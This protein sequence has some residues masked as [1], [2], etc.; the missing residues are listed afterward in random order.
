MKHSSLLFFCS[1]NFLFSNIYV[2]N[3][4]VFP[5]VHGPTFIRRQFFAGNSHG[6]WLPKNKFLEISKEPIKEHGS[7]KKLEEQKLSLFYMFDVRV[8]LAESSEL[9]TRKW[10]LE[11]EHGFVLKDVANNSNK[12][13]VFNAKKLTLEL[14]RGFIYLNG[15]R[16]SRAHI[17]IQSKD[18]FIHVN[19]KK[20]AGS[21][22]LVKQNKSYYLM[23]QLD[24]EEYIYAVLQSESWPGWPVE[25]N[26]AF[27][28]ASRS[29]LVAKICESVKRKRPYHIKDTNIHQ[30]YNFSSLKEC[31]TLRRAVEET[32][33]I[34]LAYDNK[35]VEA[36][37]DS[38]CGGIIP[39]HISGVNF[40]TAPYLKRDYACTFCKSCKIYR[41]QNEYSSQEVEALLQ[42]MGLH[43]GSLQDIRVIKKDRAGIAQE[44]LV[45]GRN[46]QKVLTGKQC[47]S[48]FTKIKSFSFNIK[49]RLDTIIFSGE[50]YGHH[51][52]IC[53]WGA[54]KMVDLK[55]NF[56]EI[57]NYFYP[58]TYCMRLA[59][60]S[61]KG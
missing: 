6:M 41:W 20:Y 47:Y 46:D 29:Y 37:F 9:D 11:S 55:K 33:G 21:L 40:E 23:S 13:G 22:L 51:L 39:A 18:K 36:M 59:H 24:I 35:P 19:G 25:V 3:K 53:Q 1:I 28:I 58:N 57:L 48:L 54:R 61:K 60:K 30:T 49:K 27:A 2:Q 12:K 15:K 10:E 31:K 17:Q 52:G 26:K 14:K 5:F 4:R 45:K 34:I 50:G 42:S 16:V 32:R 38:C 8:L 7:N 43:V 56:K 44:I